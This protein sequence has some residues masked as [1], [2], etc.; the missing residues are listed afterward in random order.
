MNKHL[1]NL[2]LFLVTTLTLVSCG[3]GGGG[4][5]QSTYGAYRSPSILASEF[6][7]AINSVDATY[8]SEVVLYADE[9]LR[10]KVAGQDQWFVIW[11]AKYSENKA[12]SLQYI[13]SLVYYDYYA[14]NRGVASEFRKIERDD[15]L[16]GDVYGDFYG[17]D[18]EVVRA[19]GNGYYQGKVSGYL[20]DDAMESK[21][22]SLAMRVGVEDANVVKAAKV[23]GVYGVSLTAA[24]DLVN[25]G[26]DVSRKL[27]RS[28]GVLTKADEAQVL[29]GM[30]QVLGV[31]VDELNAAVLDTQK[32][33]EVLATI[34]NKL[35][36]TT[37]T[38]EGKIIP[39]LGLM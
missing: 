31:G 27:D 3:G 19:V 28:G 22:T 18:Y 32:R 8:T 4:G 36:T 24:L 25:L 29:A 23:S 1:L 7:A 12:V 9:T 35:G 30:K 33:E 38:L 6:V 17:E 14:N 20:Y 10:S 37:Q 34:A 39:S 13:R 21:D 11:D 15:I 26:N 5:S 16:K 2:G